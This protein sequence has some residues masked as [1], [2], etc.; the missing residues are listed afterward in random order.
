MCVDQS[1]TDPAL[2]CEA[3]VVSSHVRQR[4]E[5]KTDRACNSRQLTVFQQVVETDFCQKVRLPAW[6]LM[7]K[8]GPFRGQRAM[9]AAPGSGG[10]PGQKVGEVEK[11][12]SASPAL[13][14]MPLQSH[15]F[16]N[17]H[18]RRHGVTDKPKDSMTCRRSF[19]G[20][21][22]GAVIEPTD[23]VPRRYFPLGHAELSPN[24]VPDDQRAGRIEAYAFDG[25]RPGFGN[26][27]GAP[28]CR[29]RQRGRSPFRHRL[30]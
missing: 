19:L 13:G 30:P 27:S 29:V 21:G 22:K 12:A 24:N 14:E 25:F 1:G 5:I 7:A 16:R 9:G 20:F 26:L 17:L 8:I 6:R 23:R 11:I 15:Q 3:D 28:G 18:F 4:P 2:G 10:F